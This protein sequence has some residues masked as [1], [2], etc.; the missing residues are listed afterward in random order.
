M[1]LP[2][3][4]TPLVAVARIRVRP[5]SAVYEIT[6]SVARVRG[7]FLPDLQ[8][9]FDRLSAL[10]APVL[11]GGSLVL[12]HYEPSHPSNG[13]AR[14]S[15]HDPEALM[16]HL[17]LEMQA[18]LHEA[19]KQVA[20]AIADEKRLAKN[21]EQE[22][23][24]S[25]EWRKK[26]MLAVDAGNDDLAKQALMRKSAHERLGVDYE[27]QWVAQKTAV[28]ALKLALQRLNSTIEEAK[29]KKNLL[30]ARARRAEAQ[31]TIDETIRDISDT[32]V[33]DVMGRLERQVEALE[34]EAGIIFDINTPG[35][36]ADLVNPVVEASRPGHGVAP[37]TPVTDRTSANDDDGGAVAV[38]LAALERTVKA[39]EA[40]AAPPA[41]SAHISANAAGPTPSTAVDH[42]RV[43]A[44]LTVPLGENTSFWERSRLLDELN[45]ALD[46]LAATIDGSGRTRVTIGCSPPSFVVDDAERHRAA[47][48]AARS[49]DDDA[50]RGT[51]LQESIGLEEVEITLLL[52]ALAG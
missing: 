35:D 23:E 46:A 41:P 45:D 27:K 3:L 10:L 33:F 18:Q 24:L 6:V 4:P 43:H 39:E 14:P 31:L 29:R 48:L 9:A 42:S 19:R 22:E 25:V 28:D 32:R 37:R 34:S 7:V 15:E 16:N 49:N 26:A 44:R 8:Q 5:D 51:L 1:P 30:I 40:A 13:P 20:V 47:L 21:H 17:L 38:R 12:T 36:D 50:S 11:G 2:R 52:P